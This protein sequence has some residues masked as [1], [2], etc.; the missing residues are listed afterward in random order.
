[1]INERRYYYAAYCYDS[2]VDNSKVVLAA[3]VPRRDPMDIVFLIQTWPDFVGPNVFSDCK[4]EITEQL[5]MFSANRIPGD[6]AGIIYYSNSS[7]GDTA[8]VTNYPIEYFHLDT[9]F[10]KAKQVLASL[11]DTVKI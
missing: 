2:A 1:M 10:E 8:H 6:R 11:N 3:A 7:L 9:N 4:K 5:N